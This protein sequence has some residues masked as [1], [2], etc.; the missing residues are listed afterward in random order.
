M[1]RRW[2]RKGKLV[3]VTEWRKR[4]FLRPFTLNILYSL[5]QFISDAESVCQTLPPLT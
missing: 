2:E 4:L 5:A 3:F 1:P